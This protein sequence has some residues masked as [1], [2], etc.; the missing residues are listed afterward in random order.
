MII[1]NTYF[2]LELT[3]YSFPKNLKIAYFIFWLGAS[4]NVQMVI[5]V[6]FLSDSVQR[7]IQKIYEKLIIFIIS[8][9]ILAYLVYF[10]MI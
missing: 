6:T 3:T 7:Y 9:G 8:C 2:A 4:H 10:D 1:E 5:R